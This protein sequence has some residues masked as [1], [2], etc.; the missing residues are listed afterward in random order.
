[1]AVVK[2]SKV[3]GAVQLR[4]TSEVVL[5]LFGLVVVISRLPTAERAPT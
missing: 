5:M 4:E 2:T 3:K 1:M